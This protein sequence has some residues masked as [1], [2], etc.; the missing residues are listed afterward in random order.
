VIVDTGSS[1]LLDSGTT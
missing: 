1:V